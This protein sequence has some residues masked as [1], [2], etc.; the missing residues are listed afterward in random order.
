MT[1]GDVTG[2]VREHADDLV[3]RFGPHDEAGIDE[4]VLPARDERIHVVFVDDQNADVV[5]P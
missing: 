4:D 5:A 2:L 3:W 1:A